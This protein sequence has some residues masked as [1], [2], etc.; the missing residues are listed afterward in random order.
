[1]SRSDDRQRT[2]LHAAITQN[3]VDLGALITYTDSR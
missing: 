1:L 2:W 3:G